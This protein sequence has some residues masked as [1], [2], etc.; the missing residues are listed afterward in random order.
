MMTPDPVRS[1]PDLDALFAAARAAEPRLPDALM[2]R[3]LA[4]AAAM[5]PRTNALPGQ[6]SRPT[7]RLGLLAG[8]IDLFGG[9]GALAGMAAAGLAGGWIGFAQPIDLQARLGLGAQVVELFPAD[10]DLWAEVLALD[11]MPEG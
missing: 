7:P 4:D 6:A 11:P 5:Q 10:L 8:L 3:V 1:E 9:R 2:A